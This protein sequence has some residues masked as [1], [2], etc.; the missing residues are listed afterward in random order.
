MADDI[1]S[2][3]LIIIKKI[4]IQLI[5]YCYAKGATEGQAVGIEGV[6]NQTLNDQASL[7]PP[8]IPT[9]NINKVGGKKIHTHH[10]ERFEIENEK[11]YFVGGGGAG[12]MVSQ[13]MIG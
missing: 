2:I 12:K 1:A 13:G 10:L 3:I 9:N 8:P 4:A 6:G 5:L 7:H 11:N